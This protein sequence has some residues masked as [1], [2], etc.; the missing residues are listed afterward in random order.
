VE[1]PPELPPEV[2]LVVVLELPPP[3]H[4]VS[5]PSG[6]IA[7]AS[8][9]I[10]SADLL[11]IVNGAITTAKAIAPPLF[12][13][14]AGLRVEAVEPAAIVNTLEPLPPVVNVTC[15]ALAVIA[16]ELVLTLKLTVPAYVVDA[17]LSVTLVEAPA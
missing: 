3:L 12:H 8:S 4:E 9:V 5:T 1:P 14:S 17:S 13:G 6:R 2:P 16:D 7:I 10:A 15:G 11:R